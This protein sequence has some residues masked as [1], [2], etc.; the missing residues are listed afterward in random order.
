M[1]RLKIAAAAGVLLLAGCSLLGGSSTPTPTGLAVGDEP[2][3]VRAG[4]NILAA[5]GSAA[6][7]AA[8]MY[9]ALSVTYPVAA[10]LGGGGIC[11]VHDAMHSRNEEIDF[12]A[13]DTAH[14]GA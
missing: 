14:G 12:L 3:A 6:D 10:G 1:Y 5:G 7:A 11:I 8:A 4:A 2:F 9:F 13:R